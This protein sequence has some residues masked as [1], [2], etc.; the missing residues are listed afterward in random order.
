M[1]TST[2]VCLGDSGIRIWN[3]PAGDPVQ[4]PDYDPSVLGQVSAL[5]WVFENS[6]ETARILIGTGLGNVILWKHDAVEASVI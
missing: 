3:L 1:G 2:K 5:K 4:I 6:K